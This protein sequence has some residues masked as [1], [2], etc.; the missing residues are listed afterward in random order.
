M[1]TIGNLQIWEASLNKL[2][3]FL[4][5]IIHKCKNTV[6]IDVVLY[7][8]SSELRFLLDANKT[9][10]LVNFVCS[11]KILDFTYQRIYMYWLINLTTKFHAVSVKLSHQISNRSLVINAV[12][13][14]ILDAACEC[15]YQP[16]FIRMK[17]CFP[18]R[19]FQIS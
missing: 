3:K 1:C 7:S 14:H 6:L 12:Y 10:N 11:W 17:M 16:S 18:S 19:L 9:F 2:K 4:W 13:G 5:K 15:P 8:I